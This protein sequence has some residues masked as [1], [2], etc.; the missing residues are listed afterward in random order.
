[1]KKTTKLKKEKRTEITKNILLSFL[2]VI[3][4]AIWAFISLFAAYD[5]FISGFFNIILGI[6]A[7]FMI[8]LLIWKE[9]FRNMKMIILIILTILV[10]IG[11]GYYY[12]ELSMKIEPMIYLQVKYGLKYREMEIIDTQKSTIDFITPGYNRSA[13]IKYNKQEIITVDYSDGQWRDNYQNIVKNEEENEKIYKKFYSI[14]KKYS[15]DFKILEDLQVIGDFENSGNDYSLIVF[16]HSESNDINVKIID[17]L[18]AYIKKYDSKYVSYGLFIV[19]D[20]NL[21][22]EMIKKDISAL[23]TINTSKHGKTSPHEV[24]EEMNYK[25]KRITFNHDGYSENIF[26]NN[27]NSLDDEYKDSKIFSNI[28]FYYG[29]EFQVFGINK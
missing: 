18:D 20:L 21:Y 28:V 7:F 25:Y 8:M 23:N 6:L 1:M 22:N 24:L 10:R 29:S 12:N 4:F 2:V 17:E 26:T 16:L 15:N 13:K 3:I 9:K 14:I 11:H 5:N 27:G 19:K